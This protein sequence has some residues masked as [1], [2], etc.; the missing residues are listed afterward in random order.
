MR[1][2]IWR[3]S[4]RSVSRASSAIW[5]A[6]ST[7]VGPGAH[8]HEGEQGGAQLGVGLDLGRLEGAE[9]A[10]AHAERA[11]E[12]LYLGGVLAPV[13]VA[14]VR[15]A[16]AAGHDQRVVGDRAR[17]WDSSDRPELQLASLEVEV[18]DLGHQHPDVGMPLEDRPQRIGDLAGR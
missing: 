15:V 11:L 3:K 9:E 18:C 17:C 12:R 13:V 1:G 10:A 8:D 7:P 16:R 5:P 2:S 6:I 14:E 4:R